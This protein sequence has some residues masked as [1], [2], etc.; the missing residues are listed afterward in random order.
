MIRKSHLSKLGRSHSQPIPFHIAK[1][2]F[3]F[4]AKAGIIHTVPLGYSTI[5]SGIYLN[6]LFR[7]I[8]SDYNF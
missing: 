8:Y 4:P 7:Y 5:K 1:R 2:P 6:L 3:V